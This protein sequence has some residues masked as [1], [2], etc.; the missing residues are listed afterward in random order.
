[1]FTLCSQRNELNGTPW[2]KNSP[3]TFM[4]KKN[5][6]NLEL[7]ESEENDENEETDFRSYLIEYA[8]R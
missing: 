7:Q 8:S 1:M 6:E 5:R 2:A 3:E 4:N